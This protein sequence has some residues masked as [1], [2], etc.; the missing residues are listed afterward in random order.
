MNLGSYFAWKNTLNNL[1]YFFLLQSGFTLIPLDVTTLDYSMQNTYIFILF[2]VINTLIKSYILEPI[3]TKHGGDAGPQESRRDI[4]PA[5]QDLGRAVEQGPPVSFTHRQH[6]DRSTKSPGSCKGDSTGTQA[7]T[8][9][10]QQVKDWE[11]TLPVG[12]MS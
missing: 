9:S 2:N 4:G 6:M 7:Q 10:F 5:E 12:A 8:L 11:K 1:C 3:T